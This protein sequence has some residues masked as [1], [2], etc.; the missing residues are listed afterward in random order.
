M[1]LPCEICGPEN[2]C[3]C[4]PCQCRSCSKPPDLVDRSRLFEVWRKKDNRPVFFQWADEQTRLI[5]AGITT[6]SSLEN[7]HE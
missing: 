1:S 4:G 6:L 3:Q 7:S 2:D 5:L